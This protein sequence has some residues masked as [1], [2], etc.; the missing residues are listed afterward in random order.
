[1]KLSNLHKRI[2]TATL[3]LLIVVLSLTVFP[4]FVFVTLVVL[5]FFFAAFEWSRLAGF[6]KLWHRIACIVAMLCVFWLFLIFAEFFTK[7]DFISRGLN[8]K[9]GIET[10]PENILEH[11][12][13]VIILAYWVLALLAIIFYPRAKQYYSG[14]IAGIFIGTLLLIPFAITLFILYTMHPLLVLYPLLL[15]FIADTA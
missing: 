7:S 12:L 5:T 9:L 15:V 13:E 14:K 1:M 6:T 8:T 4:M 2:I 3:L 11:L 10:S